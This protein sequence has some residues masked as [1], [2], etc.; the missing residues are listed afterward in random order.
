MDPVPY[1]IV[2]IERWPGETTTYR[3]QSRFRSTNGGTTTL[4]REELAKVNAANV[5]VQMAVD[6]GEIKRNGQLYA[7]TRP[8]H[9]GVIVTFEDAPK[10]QPGGAS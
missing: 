8:R 7:A 2:P 6:R 10:C 4:L 3:G 5:V 9:P 1:A